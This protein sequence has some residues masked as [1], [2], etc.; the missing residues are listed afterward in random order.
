[1]Y[2]YHKY[3]NGFGSTEVLR[4]EIFIS[5]SAVGRIYARYTRSRHYK[6]WSTDR[7]VVYSSM[8]RIIHRSDEFSKLPRPAG[9]DLPA[10][11]NFLRCA[12]IKCCFN[13]G[14]RRALS[15]DCK[16][17]FWPTTRLLSASANGG[18]HPDPQ[19]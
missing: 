16:G 3:N 7:I 6:Y 17:F 9:V 8:V 11:A 19:P 18:H 10:Q 4:P 12:R 1:M 15:R 2:R 5:C 14:S 13:E